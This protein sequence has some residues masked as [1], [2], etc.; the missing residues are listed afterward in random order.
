LYKYTQ[1]SALL[2]GGELLVEYHPWEWWHM[3]FKSQY[4]YGYNLDAYRN[5]PFIPPLEM[6]LEFDFVKKMNGKIEQLF[7]KPQATYVFAQNSVDV[8]ELTTPDFFLLNVDMGATIQISKQQKMI[9]SLGF[10]N[11]LN[12]PYYR[13]LSR[14]RILDLTEQGFNFIGSIRFPLEFGF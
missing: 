3:A 10:R 14:Y 5:L 11:I 13:H 4:V 1:A 9:V 8:N 2:T 6:T 12:T 7:I